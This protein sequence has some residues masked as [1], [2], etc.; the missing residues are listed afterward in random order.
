MTVDEQNAQ[1]ATSVS[2]KEF[3]ENTPPETQISVTGA[4]SLWANEKYRT[5]SPAIQLRCTEP[6]C[7]SV[8]WFDHQSGEAYAELKKWKSGI[9]HY[10]C[11][12]CTKG[13]KVY[14]IY[15]RPIS[16]TET[17]A[18]KIGEYPAF[19]NYTPARVISLIG[20][21]RE[22]FLQGRRAENRGLGIGAFAY[23]RR[24][25]ENQKTRIIGQI[26][27][28][29]RK[30]GASPEVIRDLE[31]AASETQ[32]SAA[33]DSIKP[34]I[35]ESL[36]IDGHNP[37]KLLYSAL[38]KCIHEQDDAKCL[39]LAESIRV[40]LTELS[41]RIALA[42]KEHAELKSAVSKILQVNSEK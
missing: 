8:M 27:K 7:N 41:E 33:I 37:L 12:H 11:R 15:V 39:Q 22:M 16:A 21:D 20:P 23:Y 1:P 40:I 26:L 35:P 31:A 2:W 42:L 13:W 17:I 34:T 32:F 4:T 10:R 29:A 30:V 24:V 14:A 5:N 9:L 3:L 19:G 25:V 28:V 36:L 6:E 18:L 38:S